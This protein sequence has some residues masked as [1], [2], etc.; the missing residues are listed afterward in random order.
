MQS[1]KF[2]EIKS[3]ILIL[4]FFL[5]IPF[6]GFTSAQDN[7]PN[8]DPLNEV[9]SWSFGRYT[10]VAIDEVRSLAFVSSGGNVV[11]LDISNPASPVLVNDQISTNGV[12]NDLIYNSATQNLYLTL[13]ENGLEI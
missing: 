7:N 13:G 6:T 3:H 8:G 4:L 5:L 1:R 11:I 12:V 2:T 9:G 10:E